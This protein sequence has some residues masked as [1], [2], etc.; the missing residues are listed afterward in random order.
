M[1]FPKKR[2]VRHTCHLS[3]KEDFDTNWIAC[4]Y[5]VE[6]LQFTGFVLYHI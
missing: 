5:F 4:Q 6:I 1:Y 3:C 2:Y